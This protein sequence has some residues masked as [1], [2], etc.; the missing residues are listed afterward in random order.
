[1]ATWKDIGQDNLES[2]IG[3]LEA[4]FY[5][6][7]VSR[8]YYAV[9]S[10]LTFELVQRGAKDN[11]ANRDTPSHRQLAGLLEAQ[12]THFSSEKRENLIRVLLHLYGARIGSDY[13]PLRVDRETAKSAFRDAEYIFKIV[14]T[15]T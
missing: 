6:S 10:L 7:S 5:R 15:K 1:V 2:A 12:F 13:S 8:F 11:F 3:L 9:F 14:G 4:K